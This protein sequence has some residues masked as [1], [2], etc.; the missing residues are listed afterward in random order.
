MAGGVPHALMSLAAGRSITRTFHRLT[1]LLTVLS[2][3]DHTLAM[4]LSELLIS[5]VGVLLVPLLGRTSH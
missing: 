4:V 1:A 3:V 2:V 5:M